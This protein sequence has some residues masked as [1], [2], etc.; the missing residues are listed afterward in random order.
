[1]ET[2]SSF[3]E[4]QRHDAR[5][6]CSNSCFQKIDCK[7]KR[8]CDFIQENLENFGDILLRIEGLI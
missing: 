1:M 7:Y 8:S 6:G 4:S 3:S 2:L 5:C